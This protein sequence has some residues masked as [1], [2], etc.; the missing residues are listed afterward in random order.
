MDGRYVLTQPDGTIFGFDNADEPGLRSPKYHAMLE[1]P[2]IRVFDIIKSLSDS[3]SDDLL[4]LHQPDVPTKKTKEPGQGE[5]IFVGITEEGGYYALSE[6]DFPLIADQATIAAC[7]QKDKA[8]KTLPRQEREKSLVGI[9]TVQ[10][11]GPK[12]YRPSLPAPSNYEDQSSYRNSAPASQDSTSGSHY[13]WFTGFLI[14]VV[15]AVVFLGLPKGFRNYYKSVSISPTGIT[16]EHRGLS[17][18]ATEQKPDSQAILPV[19]LEVENAEIPEEDDGLELAIMDVTPQEPDGDAVEKP[20]AVRFEEP[21]EENAVAGTVTSSPIE[22]GQAPGETS[23]GEVP[24]VPK[25]KK[26]SRGRRGGKN[27][28]KGAAA[29]EKTEKVEDVNNEGEDENI[30]VVNRE[31]VPADKQSTIISTGVVEETQGNSPFIL[32]N[33]QIDVRVIGINYPPHPPYF[34]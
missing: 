34:C 18:A 29:V 26:Y 30:E 6:T 24:V 5:K 19:V 4:V 13:S 10:Y 8:W 15:F 25:K 17:V 1:S 22:N 28:S 14:S 16:W 7:Y 11:T 2:A 12:A 9:H 27:K 3:A 20:A 33:L 23:V 32:N 21:V 31:Q